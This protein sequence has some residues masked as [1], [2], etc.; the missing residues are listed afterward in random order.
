MLGHAG[1]EASGL[2]NL[3]DTSKPVKDGGLC[4][5]A[6]FGVERNGENLLAEGC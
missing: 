6:N 5:R 3:Y 1:D 4:F 2:P